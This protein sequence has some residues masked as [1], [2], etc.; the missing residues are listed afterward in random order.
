MAKRF[1]R[2]LACRAC[3]QFQ[4]ESRMILCGVFTY[5]ATC[6]HDPMRDATASIIQ[7]FCATLDLFPHGQELKRDMSAECTAC[8]MSHKLELIDGMS[9]GIGAMYEFVQGASVMDSM[10]EGTGR[11]G[12]PEETCRFGMTEEPGMTEETS[13]TPEEPNIT[14]ETRETNTT[15]ETNTAEDIRWV[16][17]AK[18][19]GD[20][21]CAYGAM[22]TPEPYQQTL[23]RYPSTPRKDRRQ[24]H[25]PDDVDIIN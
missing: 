8:S 9:E 11:F 1:V 6:Q 3:G 20:A 13:S 24:R 15:E 4:P 12:M 16:D 18:E 23:S 22:L 5:C 14:E 17:A 21:L 19:C 10:M 2:G 7:P 25:R